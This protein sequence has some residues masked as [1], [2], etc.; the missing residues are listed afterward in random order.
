MEA[1][2]RM[3]RAQTAALLSKGWKPCAIAPCAWLAAPGKA[4]CGPHLAG[5]AGFRSLDYTVDR[6]GEVDGV[7]W[8]ARNERHCPEWAEVTHE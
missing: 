8:D 2:W 3:H 5:H 7:D 4:E 6:Y 1:E